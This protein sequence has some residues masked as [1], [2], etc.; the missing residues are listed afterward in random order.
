MSEWGFGV[1]QGLL[2]GFVFG[3]CAVLFPILARRNKG[4]R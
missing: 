2:M 3:V 4:K 1:I